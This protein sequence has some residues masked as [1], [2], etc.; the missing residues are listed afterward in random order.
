MKC[1]LLAKNEKSTQ[2]GMNHKICV[3]FQ[4]LKDLQ[5]WKH[6]IVNYINW[7]LIPELSICFSFW[8]SSALCYLLKSVDPLPWN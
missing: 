3:L 1:Y 6:F 5:G 2:T 8:L 4:K 7:F